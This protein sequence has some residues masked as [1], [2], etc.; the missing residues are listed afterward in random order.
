MHRTGVLG[1]LLY[2][3]EFLNDDNELAIQRKHPA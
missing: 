3:V 2:N 1:E